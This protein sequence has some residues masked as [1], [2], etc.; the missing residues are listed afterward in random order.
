MHPKPVFEFDSFLF[1]IPD[2]GAKKQPK[3]NEKEEERL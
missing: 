3:E 2:R 1:D